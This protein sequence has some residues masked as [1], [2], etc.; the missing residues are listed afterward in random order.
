MGHAINGTIG[1]NF[2][3]IETTPYQSAGTVLQGNDGF[4]EYVKYTAPVSAG[5]AVVI[6]ASG[7]A[8][9]L[10][11]TLASTTYQKVG[12]AQADATVANTFG[13]VWRGNG[14]NTAILANGT[15][16][17]NLTSTATAGVLGTGGTAVVGARGTATGITNTRVGITAPTLLAVNI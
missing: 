5:H 7:N 6:D 1:V 17:G 8:Q 12:I 14:S 9:G 2:N 11:T 4:Y 16:A 10:T 15:S 3:D 13:W